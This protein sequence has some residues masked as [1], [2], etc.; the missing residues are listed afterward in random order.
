MTTGSRSA[1]EITPERKLSD[2]CTLTEEQLAERRTWVEREIAPHARRR[3]K[4]DDGV[5]WEFDASPQTR[6]RLE[7]LAELE[8][9]CCGPA[10]LSFAVRSEG[11]DTLRFEILGA[12][13]AALA[14]AIDTGTD[15]PRSRT[16]ARVART[17][18]IA[19]FAAVLVCCL[20]PIGVATLV[21]AAVAGPLHELDDPW[22]I[23]G[24]AAV[25][26]IGMWQFEKRSAKKRATPVTPRT[27]CGC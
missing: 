9:R 22:V 15:S 18:G 21:G 14:R 2:L 25:F 27:D 11:D 24:V 6:E 23:G 10:D 19:T 17:A 3:L 4:L 20:V 1:I 26:G 5:A 12:N 13:A 16:I 8:R 7:H